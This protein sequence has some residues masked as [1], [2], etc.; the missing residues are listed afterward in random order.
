MSAQPLDQLQA[1]AI[2]QPA[3]NYQGAIVDFAY[4]QPSGFK[5]V[6]HVG[7][8]ARAAQRLANQLGQPAMVFNECDAV[9][10]E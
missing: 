7:T 3:V 9:H 10:G 1:V 8:N 2:G 6:K 4:G 5:V